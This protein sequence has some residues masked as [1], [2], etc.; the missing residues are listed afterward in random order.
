MCKHLKTG[1]TEKFEADL[2]DQGRYAR[3]GSEFRRTREYLLS[4]LATKHLDYASGISQGIPIGSGSIESTVRRVVN[5][6][7]KNAS[8]FWL[9]ENAED[10][11]VLRSFQ[12]SGRHENIVKQGLLAIA[13]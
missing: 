10:L 12:K 8:M 5:L 9:K 1:K 2:R 6:R 3:K 4:R 11:L 7:L 13:G